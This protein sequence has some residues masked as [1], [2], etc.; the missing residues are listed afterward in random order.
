MQRYQ[1]PQ[2]HICGVYTRDFD[3]WQRHVIVTHGND[4]NLIWQ[5]VFPACPARK[6][7]FPR[8]RPYKRHVSVYHA[9]ENFAMFDVHFEEIDQEELVQRIDVP[10]GN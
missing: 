6:K 1:P 4:A 9:E 3:Q 2:C 10:D 8:Y 7:Q 5:C